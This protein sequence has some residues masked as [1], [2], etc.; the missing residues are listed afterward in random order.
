MPIKEH[1][2][3]CSNMRKLNKVGEVVF[4]VLVE[5]M[6]SESSENKLST[7]QVWAMYFPKLTYQASLPAIYNLE[8][9]VHSV[10]SCLIGKKTHLTDHSRFLVDVI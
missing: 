7:S 4:V 5:D 10:L 3:F 8:L 9:S 6:W 1:A 2:T